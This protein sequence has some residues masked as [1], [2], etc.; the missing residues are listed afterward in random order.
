[1]TKERCSTLPILCEFFLNNDKVLQEVCHKICVVLLSWQDHYKIQLWL[2]KQHLVRNIQ[3]KRKDYSFTLLA[4]KY[5]RN[6]WHIFG[7][8]YFLKISYKISTV[9]G[10]Y[11]LRDQA[12]KERKVIK[13]FYI[14]NFLNS[15]QF[16][17][18]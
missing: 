11:P 9:F 8:A 14:K 4:K 17:C 16:S 1:M 13:D 18:L 3:T 6:W 5:W 2:S 7:L 12:M 15:Y 10:H